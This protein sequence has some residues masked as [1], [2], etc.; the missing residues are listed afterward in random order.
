M[1]F[2]IE[3]KKKVKLPGDE[4]TPT[5]ESRSAK[6][7]GK[8][9]K[10][11][12]SR[13][14][15]FGGH[16][17]SNNLDPE[18]NSTKTI[19]EDDSVSSGVVSSNFSVPPINRS[20]LEDQSTV[21]NFLTENYAEPTS[22]RRATSVYE[23]PR[24][25]VLIKDERTEKMYQRDVDYLSSGI[26]LVDHFSLSYQSLIK[27]FPPLIDT[28]LARVYSS[29]M[30][31]N[32][33]SWLESAGVGFTLDGSGKKPAN[34]R[35][36]QPR[37]ISAF[38]ITIAYLSQV[39]CDTYTFYSHLADNIQT[40][41]A[42]AVYKD[43]CLLCPTER[44]GGESV[45]QVTI[46]KIFASKARP[47]LLETKYHENYKLP[48]GKLIF[49]EG[50]CLPDM[51]TTIMMQVFNTI[52]TVMPTEPKYRPFIETY[53][54][55]PLGNFR[56]GKTLF[57]AIECVPGISLEDLDWADLIPVLEDPEKCLHFLRTAVGAYCFT[58]CMALRDRH[59]DNMM[60]K[61]DEF[62][63]PKSFLMIDF[64]FILSDD[65]VLAPTLAIQPE[66]EKLLKK[67]HK[68][69]LFCKMFVEAYIHIHRNGSLISTCSYY[70]FSKI[71]L[72]VSVVL[73]G[74]GMKYDDYVP[75]LLSERLMVQFSETQI[76]KFI[77]V[78][79]QSASKNLG[80]NFNNLFHTQMV[81]VLKVMNK[82][83]F[84][85]TNEEDREN[86]K[87]L[88]NISVAGTARASLVNAPLEEA[89]TQQPPIRDTTASSL[90]SPSILQYLIETNSSAMSTSYSA[91]ASTTNSPV[92]TNP[93]QSQVATGTAS[94]HQPSPGSNLVSV[95]A[96]SQSVTPYSSPIASTQASSSSTL[97]TTK[98]KDECL[99]P[100]IVVSTSSQ[101]NLD[102]QGLLHSRSTAT[103][104]ST[105]VSPTS[106]SAEKSID[107]S[108]TRSTK[109][110][111]EKEKKHH[112][113][114]HD[115]EKE[116]RHHRG[117]RKEKERRASTKEK[118][119]NNKGNSDSPPT[120]PREHS[121]RDLTSSRR[122]SGSKKRG[123]SVERGK[124][125]E[126]KRD[127]EVNSPNITESL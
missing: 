48:D 75:Q 16:S 68:W 3:K 57:G 105:V 8:L 56:E 116:K 86:E 25:S 54:V 119:S 44:R 33:L 59:K 1:K 110:E 112:H 37:M 89:I 103:P 28:I 42:G 19:P 64:E 77:D 9:G 69:K 46:T 26:N 96:G 101:L 91:G 124:S 93:S 39:H 31:S 98:L 15:H 76:R 40:L 18:T 120:S 99:P 94:T 36:K 92:N 38:N 52:W 49:K 41:K 126:R 53:T 78:S 29:P 74:D 71:P 115:R 84:E 97:P 30:L 21:N 118:D 61:L 66:F 24:L 45:V 111:D 32:L 122:H 81:S 50:N 11:R 107:E 43:L 102:T 88:S 90:G 13:K 55:L 17:T 108:S 7:L 10:I 63:K 67:M 58:Y 127:N 72:G 87:T 23:I 22:P 47:L 70:L 114:K 62:G 85:N 109:E 82:R 34:F 106:V 14:K 104:L 121:P 125:L 35:E 65:K 73:G 27:T 12:A 123:K 51:L 80:M 117:S 2:W 100:T 83:D 113:E 5:K 20:S 79:L 6:A 60:I 95:S 4:E